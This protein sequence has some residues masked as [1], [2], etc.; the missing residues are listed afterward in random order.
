MKYI[1]TKNLDYLKYVPCARQHGFE[2]DL[3][4]RIE[5]IYLLF[6]DL[7]KM[8]SYLRFF[9]Q[10]GTFPGFVDMTLQEKCEVACEIVDTLPSSPVSLLTTQINIGLL[11]ASFWKQVLYLKFLILFC[12]ISHALERKWFVMWKIYCWQINTCYKS[13]GKISQI[14]VEANKTIWENS[15]QHFKADNE[16]WQCS[17]ELLMYIISFNINCNH[18]EERLDVTV[19]N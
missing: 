1:F 16:F 13:P 11:Q 7:S 15:A 10:S 5:L 4:L 3:G 2:R 19:E 8:L 17:F 6:S 18:T 14:S 12:V 9:F